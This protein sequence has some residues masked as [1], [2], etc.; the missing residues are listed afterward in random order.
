[1]RNK[2]RLHNLESFAHLE[3][4]KFEDLPPPLKNAL[5]VRPYLRVVT[6]LKQTDADLKYEVF[7]RLNC[8]GEPLNAQEI[9]NVVFRGPFNDLLI[10][11]STED[12]L[13]SQLKI[14]GKSAS[15]YRQMLDVEYVLRFLTLRENWH[16]FSGSL[17]TSMDHF[18]RE[19]RK[20][21]SSEITRFRHAFKFAIRACEEIW[22]DVAF[23]RPY[24]GSWRDQMLA[25]MYDAQMLAISELGQAKL[26][27]LKKHK[28]A[29]I[30]K[31]K[32]LFQDPSFETAVRQGTNTPSRILHRV[33]TMR[34]MLLSFT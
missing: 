3:R 30:E 11:L 21:S 6:L 2:L 29:I 7:R 4:A 9:R 5:T 8:G 23:L 18:M 24:N 31:T 12:F 22:G 19:N 14:K 1:M 32:S 17:R 10:E 34:S 13:K 25:G 16:G 33:D 26:P 20:I 15:A 28:K 27:A